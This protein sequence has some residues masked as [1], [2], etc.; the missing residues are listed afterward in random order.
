MWVYPLST[1]SAATYSIIPPP[2]DVPIAA[3]DAM[4]DDQAT[5]VQP[6][7]MILA[8]RHD[9]G[10]WAPP[11]GR[12]TIG[13]DTHR[14]RSAARSASPLK[15][16]KSRARAQ[17]TYRRPSM[18][19]L[20]PWKPIAKQLF[21]EGAATRPSAPPQD[22]PTR[23]MSQMNIPVSGQGV[24]PAQTPN[25]KGKGAAVSISHRR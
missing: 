24:T 1:K 4:V 7:A 2:F 18:E 10:R 23:P 20:S 16:P 17:S 3:S 13:R 19:V 11:R 12:P 5:F 22:A 14:P 25:V 15:M 21:K 6:L 9:K 8:A